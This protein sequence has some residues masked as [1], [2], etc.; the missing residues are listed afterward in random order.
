MRVLVTGA[1][2]FLGGHLCEAL[3]GRHEIV[4]MVRRNSDT[5]LLEGLGVE[6]RLGDLSDPSSLDDAV[7]GVDAVVHL[8]A[9]YTLTGE[10]GQY[11]A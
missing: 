3:A 7:R 8:A 10:E 11:H 1:S 6:L 9:Y 2:G 4:G 5:S